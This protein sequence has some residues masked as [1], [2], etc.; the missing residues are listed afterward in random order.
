MAALDKSYDAPEY[1]ITREMQYD[2]VAVASTVLYY[3]QFYA[4]AR[5]YVT[6]I[7]VGMRSAA[8]A[9]ALTAVVGHKISQNV[10]F[11]L[12]AGSLVAAWI[13]ATSVGSYQTIVVNRTLA[14]GEC[15]GVK[16]SDA[17]GKYH[18]LYEYQILPA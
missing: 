8:S 4:R 17:K 12:A 3:A 7:V 18:V 15:L 11:S 1:N 13:S 16:F 9:A 5:M 2:N 14:L 10:A 6:N